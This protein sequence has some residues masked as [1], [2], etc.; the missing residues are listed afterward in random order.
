MIPIDPTDFDIDAFI[1]S[2]ELALRFPIAERHWRSGEKIEEIRSL[3]EDID[4]KL[5]DS[6]EGLRKV[7]KKGYPDTFTFRIYTEQEFEKKI[8]M[9]SLILN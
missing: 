9:G 7:N 1:V 6:L 8:K 5:K 2:D 3:Q 4:R